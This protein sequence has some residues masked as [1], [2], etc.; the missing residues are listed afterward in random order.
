VVALM[1]KGF[2]RAEGLGR[3]RAVCSSGFGCRSDG[4][5]SN[6]RGDDRWVRRSGKSTLA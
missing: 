4:D 2:G 5:R 1:G 6:A 3:L